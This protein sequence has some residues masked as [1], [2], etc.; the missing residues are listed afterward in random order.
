V[1]YIGEAESD[2]DQ[3]ENASYWWVSALGRS[4]SSESQGGTAP[5]ELA[6]YGPDATAPRCEP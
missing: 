6:M 5:A 2:I 4:H 1:C 3:L